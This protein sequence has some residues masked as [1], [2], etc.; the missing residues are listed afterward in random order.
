MKS[1][2]PTLARAFDALADSFEIKE[3]YTGDESIVCRAWDP[4]LRRDV[5]IKTPNER[6]LADPQ[7]FSRY[8]EEARNLAAIDDPNV[9]HVNE[10]IDA[11]ERS[12]RCYLVASWFDQ[13]LATRHRQRPLTR[14]EALDLLERLLSGLV[15]IHG[16]SLFHRDLTPD[17]VLVSDDLKKV[18]IAD[19]GGADQAGQGGFLIGP[20]ARYQPPETYDSDLPFDARADLYSAGFIAYELL[21]GA[22]LFKQTF[23]AVLSAND[24]YDR[25]QRWVNWH[26][27]S[28]PVPLSQLIGLAEPVS[29]VVERLLDKDVERRYASAEEA[30]QELRRAR[31]APTESVRSPMADAGLKPIILD[32]PRKK[33]GGLKL[34]WVLGGVGGGLVLL[35]AVLLLLGGDDPSKIE[36]DQAR[37][38]MVAARQA[39]MEAGADKPLPVPEFAAASGQVDEARQ[40][41]GEQGYPEAAALLRSARDRYLEAKRVAEAEPAAVAARGRA[42]AAREAAGGDAAGD[43]YAAAQASWSTAEE[44]FAER[45]YLASGPAHDAAAS[46]YAEVAREFAAAARDAAAGAID[47]QAYE[48]AQT[49]W[50]Q[51]ETHHEAGE[52]AQGIAAYVSA[53][54]GFEAALE[55]VDELI[56][57]AATATRA[58]AQAA[59][60]A[61]GGDSAGPDY[62]APEAL[63]LRAEEAF[64]GADFAVST[65]AHDEASVGFAEVARGLAR[66]AKQAAEDASELDAY[67]DA[68]AYWSRGE[69]QYAAG[70]HAQSIAAHLLAVAAFEVAEH[71]Q[72]Q[73]E[74]DAARRAEEL[75][76]LAGE[77]M[78]AKQDAEAARAEAES[79]DGTSL[80]ISAEASAATAQEA[81]DAERWQ[82]AIDGYR[83]AAQGFR[84]ALQAQ[85]ALAAQRAARAAR[86]QAVA[87]GADADALTEA[88]GIVAAA[89]AALEAQTYADAQAAFERAEQAFIAAA[90]AAVPRDPVRYRIGSEPAEIDALLSLCERESAQ[91][92]RSDFDTEAARE[93]EIEPFAIDATEVTNARFLEFV[94]SES[95]RTE[96]EQRGYSYMPQLMGYTNLEGAA[97]RR[98][99]GPGSSLDGR[100]TEPVVHVTRQDAEAFCRWAGGQLPTEAQWELAARGRE[101][102]IFPWGMDWR[103]EAVPQLRRAAPVGSTDAGR[104]PNGIADMAGN[105]WEWTASDLDGK[106]VLKGGSWRERYNPTNLRSAVQLVLKPD[107]SQYDVGFRCAYPEAHWDKRGEPVVVTAGERAEGAVE[108][109]RSE[110]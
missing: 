98:P 32:A 26:I 94:A 54:A 12:P 37:A 34:S 36:A 110:P 35:L 56:E 15:A 11:G 44:R 69:A 16:Q 5:A 109:D 61:A 2:D 91:C 87:A 9:L 67:A 40:R 60:D 82:Q 6:V 45:A 74:Q 19:F 49:L 24:D 21:L 27:T 106:A 25:N 99:E 107:L 51:A 84:L 47:Q 97:W 101:R 29:M 88:D 1:D 23:S 95:F 52:L 7:R 81:L 65:A 13:N 105:L 103:A 18:C 78:Q 46:G 68:Q 77:A 64:A 89:E 62:A 39:A 59:R 92:R 79:A 42:E 33:A 17:N 66:Q 30:L 38:A 63:W 57:A 75:E 43:R 55:Q 73:R 14:D 96:S 48:D 3:C 83:A 41:Y 72:Q 76:R 86:E 58:R 108:Q 90:Q 20:S 31:R 4:R 28:R 80:F 71:E 93:V 8:I 22:D 104:T 100:E 85:P 102:R 53:A 50:T 10:F 70:D